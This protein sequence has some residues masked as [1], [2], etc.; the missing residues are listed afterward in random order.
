MSF[1]E[2]IIQPDFQPIYLSVPLKPTQQE[3]LS[4]K[5]GKGRW[6]AAGP[7]VLAGEVGS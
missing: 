7:E 3:S 2:R 5:W 1:Q 4:V 6:G